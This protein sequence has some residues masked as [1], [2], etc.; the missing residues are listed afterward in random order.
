MRRLIVFKVSASVSLGAGHVM[1]CL[2]LADRLAAQGFSIAFL[3]GPRTCRVVPTL[4]SRKYEVRVIAEDASPE[5][6]AHELHTHWPNGA[7]WLVIDDYRHG[8]DF[9]ARCRSWAARILVIDDL[10]NRDHA[11]DYLLDQAEDRRPEHYRAL[12]PPGCEMMLGARYALLR[13]QF[14]EARSSAL[15]RREGELQRILIAMGGTDDADYSSIA[16]KA[17]SETGIPNLALDVVLGAGSP[18]IAK[19][20]KSIACIDNARLHVAI[21]DMASLMVGADLAIG[22][23]GI[24]SWERCCLGLPS[25]LITAAENQQKNAIA[26]AAKGAARCIDAINNPLNMV[27]IVATIRELREQPHLLRSMAKRAA[28]LCDGNGA[29]RV[30]SR[31][32]AAS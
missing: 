7:T 19:V 6:C 14:A 10:A 18:H 16:I 15:A 3:I 5:A 2:A 1:R 32:A 31:L 9:E 22:A 17:V 12:V 8:V 24:S 27:A 13:E 28:T 30:A 26:L 11:C 25:I 23:G 20:R 21:D 4:S 29:S